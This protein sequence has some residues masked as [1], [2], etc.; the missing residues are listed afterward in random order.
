MAVAK[1]MMTAA[2]AGRDVS[3]RT[4]NPDIFDVDLNFKCEEVKRN[5]ANRVCEQLRKLAQLLKFALS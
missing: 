1:A 4:V 2:R 5:W 3:N